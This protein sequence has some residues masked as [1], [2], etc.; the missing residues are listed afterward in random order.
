MYYEYRVI[1]ESLNMHVTALP[2]GTLNKSCLIKRENTLQSGA[3]NHS[4]KMRHPA[5]DE[6]QQQQQQQ[7][8]THNSYYVR[9]IS[10]SAGAAAAAVRQQQAAFPV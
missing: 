9:V 4:N 8:L 5:H 2:R 1:G 7:P 10:T 3:I 6:E